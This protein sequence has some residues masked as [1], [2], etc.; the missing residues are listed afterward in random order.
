MDF[1]S[2]P[3]TH[4]RRRTHSSP[5]CGR[6]VG[7]GEKRRRRCV[8]EGCG[9]FSHT[10]IST[11]RE[12]TGWGDRQSGGLQLPACSAARRPRQA[13]PAQRTTTP[14]LHRASRR[15]S[16][17]WLARIAFPAGGVALLPS[18]RQQESQQDGGGPSW[19]VTGWWSS[20][21]APVAQFLPRPRF[22]LQLM[23]GG[24]EKQG[25]GGLSEPLPPSHG[26]PQ[27]LSQGIPGELPQ[28]GPSLRQPQLSLPHQEDKQEADDEEESR[29]TEVRFSSVPPPSYLGRSVLLR[30]KPFPP[31]Q[32]LSV[33]VGERRESRWGQQVVI[34]PF[35]QKGE[36][37][38]LFVSPHPS[39]LPFFKLPSIPLV[40][41]LVLDCPFLLAI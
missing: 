32:S 38:V 1:A 25:E 14:I 5:C 18:P 41:R 15:F 16:I 13:S 26:P 31:P 40:S 24:E 30:E 39:F 9:A 37:L 19:G 6:G 4:K 10:S 3:G 22:S 2:S 8:R 28:D 35:P 20:A 23:A 17:G 34:Y 27:H 21:N 12:G 36:K 29:R 33:V 7:G 11:R